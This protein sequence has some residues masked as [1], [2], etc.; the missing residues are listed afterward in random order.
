[1]K[2]MELE[3]LV[4]SKISILS[5]IKKNKISV[6]SHFT[7]NLFFDTLDLIELSLKLENKY[8]IVITNKKLIKIKTVSDMVNCVKEKI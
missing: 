1:M 4:I 6:T 7:D 2:I 8:N 5:G 3:N